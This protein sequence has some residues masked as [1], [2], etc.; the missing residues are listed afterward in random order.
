MPDSGVRARNYTLRP[1][2][3][4]GQSASRG[5][6][7]RCQHSA[8]FVEPCALHVPL[9]APQRAYIPFDLLGGKALARF[10]A[11]KGDAERC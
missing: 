6:G 10:P 4:G 2:I 5:Y 11:G 3:D 9:F 7:S 8:A 1:C